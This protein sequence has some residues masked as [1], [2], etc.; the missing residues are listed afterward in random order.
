MADDHLSLS[1]YL[2]NRQLFGLNYIFEVGNPPILLN[3]IH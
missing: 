1:E 3:S 2:V